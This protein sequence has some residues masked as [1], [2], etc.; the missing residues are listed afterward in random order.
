MAVD[1]VGRRYGWAATRRKPGRAVLAR[2]RTRTRSASS[3]FSHQFRKLFKALDLP[4]IRLLM[5]TPHRVDQAMGDGT[6]RRRQP[7]FVDGRSRWL[8]G[9]S[10]RS[11]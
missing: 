1:P 11:V 8:S 4:P 10:R 6:A 3:Y 2:S 5:R 9:Q 7:S